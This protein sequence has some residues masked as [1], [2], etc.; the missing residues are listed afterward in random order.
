MC[1][2][3]QG[4]V[5]KRIP[6]ISHQCASQSNTLFSFFHCTPLL[7]VRAIQPYRELTVNNVLYV[8]LQPKNDTKMCLKKVIS[9][10][11]RQHNIIV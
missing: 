8:H 11:Q 4:I 5:F 2:A 1:S 9:P 7:I 3:K 10:L 6:F